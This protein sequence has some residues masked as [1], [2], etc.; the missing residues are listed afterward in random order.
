MDEDFFPEPPLDIS[1][2]HFEIV[3]YAIWLYTCTCFAV[4]EEWLSH[5]T[6]L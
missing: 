3:L 5:D 2:F 1:L 4:G 6:D